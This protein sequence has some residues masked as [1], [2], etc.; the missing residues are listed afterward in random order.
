VDLAA[1]DSGGV[2]RASATLFRPTAEAGRETAARA[3][4]VTLPHWFIVLLGLPMPLPR[5]RGARRR[6]AAPPV[7]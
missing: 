1:S 4:M 7:P 3:W 6:R 2:V 5:L